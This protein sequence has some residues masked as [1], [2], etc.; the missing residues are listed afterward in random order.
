MLPLPVM[1]AKSVNKLV[2]EY[3]LEIKLKQIY[4]PSILINCDISAYSMFGNIQYLMLCYKP[5]AWLN[6]KIVPY[7]SN[8]AANSKQQSEKYRF[9]NIRDNFVFEPY[10]P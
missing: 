3:H 8:A 2:P 5:Q 9:G 6:S 7:Y 1:Q 4:V 10:K